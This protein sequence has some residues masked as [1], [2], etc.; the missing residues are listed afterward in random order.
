M[1][2]RK[3]RE[4]LNGSFVALQSRPYVLP[5][6]S[7]L[8]KTSSILIGAREYVKFLES[9][10]SELEEKNREL[11]AR[12]VSSPAVVAKNDEEEAAAPPEAGGEVKRERIGSSH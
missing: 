3:R 12:L 6:G 11:E 5:P 8:D 2:E 10:L 1:S 7:K 9:K 4:K